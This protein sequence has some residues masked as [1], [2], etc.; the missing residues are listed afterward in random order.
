MFNYVFKLTL[1]RKITIK[2]NNMVDAIEKFKKE[3]PLLI[4]KYS[5]ITQIDQHGNNLGGIK[6]T[7]DGRWAATVIIPNEK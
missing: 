7:K 2:A 4:G 3:N 6:K 5:S 1:G